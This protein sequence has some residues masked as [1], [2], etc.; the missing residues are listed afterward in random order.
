[1]SRWTTI[2]LAVLLFAGLAVVIFVGTPAAPVSPV[3]ALLLDFSRADVK[4]LDVKGPGMETRFVRDEKDRDRWRVQVGGSWVRAA[5]GEVEDLL[6]DL[7]R[8]SPKQLFPAAEVKADERKKWGMEAPGLTVRLGFE[9]R[10]VRVAFGTDLLERKNTYAETAPNSDIYVVPSAVVEK[11]KMMSP[12]AFRERKPIGLSKW[13]VKD[14]SIRRAD[15]MIFE[16]EQVSGGT[17]WEVLVPYKGSADPVRIGEVLERAL[18]VEVADFVPDAAPDPDKYGFVA[19]R[20]EIRIRKQGSEAPIV[21]E[22]GKDAPDGKVYFREKGEPSVYTCKKALADAVARLDPAAIRDRNV[23]RL[24]WT[25]LESIEFIHPEQPWKLLRVL[26]RW[27]VEKPERTPAD[28][29]RVEAF[30]TLLRELEAT[31]FLD[32]EKP[33]AHGLASAETAAARLELHG[34]DHAGDR[35]LLLGKRG[36]DGSLPVRLLPARDSKEESPVAIVPGAFLERLLE[37]WLSFR[38]LEVFAADLDE[39]RGIVRKRADGEESYLREGGAWKAAPGGKEPDQ[40]ALTQ[41]LTFLL[42]MDCSAY[43]KKTKE[44]LEAYGLGEPPAGPSITLRLGKKGQEERTRTLVIGAKTPGGGSRFARTAD[45]DLV[46]LLPEQVLRGASVVDFFKVMDGPWD[47]RPKEPEAPPE[48]PKKVEPAKP[49]EPP[50]TPE[51]PKE[52]EKAEP[53]K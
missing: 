23:L 21:L 5:S 48:E 45:G 29:P 39:I 26:E 42:R 43:V 34:V 35:T 4:A 7:S 51:S 40:D 20:A 14:L 18:N 13:D 49:P 36:A 41:V 1:V 31:K 12:D 28:L 9:G 33:E 32:G 47:K 52:P 25:R 46:F 16:A 53:P 15:G 8:I 44:G 2:V 37:G 10:D 38:G 19:P 50:K 24:G 30:H 11:L 3:P 27:D 17:S 22:I 6:N